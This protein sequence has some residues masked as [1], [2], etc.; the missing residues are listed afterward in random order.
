MGRAMHTLLEAYLSKDISRASQHY[1]GLG[2]QEG[3]DLENTLR[4]PNVIKDYS[5]V[6][7]QFKI[8]TYV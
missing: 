6:N 3:V 2:M 8:K 7:Y 1:N 4:Y 5:D